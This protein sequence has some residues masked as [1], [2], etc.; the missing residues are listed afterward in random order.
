M[1]EKKQDS[2]EHQERSTVTTLRETL[3]NLKEEDCFS[4]QVEIGGES[5]K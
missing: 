3:E 1:P 5:K 4:I 2:I